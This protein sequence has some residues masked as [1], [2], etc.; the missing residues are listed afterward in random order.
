LIFEFQNL[1]SIYHH[2]YHRAGMGHLKA[3]NYKAA[4]VNFDLALAHQNSHYTRYYL[5]IAYLFQKEFHNALEQIELCLQMYQYRE[6]YVQKI[7]CLIAL[8]NLDAALAISKLL[9]RASENCHQIQAQLANIYFL[10]SKFKYAYQKY[11]LAASIQPMGMYFIS[12]AD[13][14]N[15]IGENP[16][17]E[18][19]QAQIAF[20]NQG[21]IQE[22]RRAY[23]LMLPYLNP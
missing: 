10:L 2:N 7:N 12:M 19:Q 9:A 20:E 1:G 16:L 23:V 18:L 5:S 17:L 4:I 15:K 6:F 8:D 3:K 14:K 13:C 11:Q 22:S 21:M